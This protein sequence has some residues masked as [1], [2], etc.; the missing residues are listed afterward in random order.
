[1]SVKCYYSITY[2]SRVIL[3]SHIVYIIYIELME[4]SASVLPNRLLKNS[5]NLVEN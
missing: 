4:Y 2:P 5:T 3:P 1:M